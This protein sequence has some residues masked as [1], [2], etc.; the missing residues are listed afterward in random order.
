LASV[1]SALP[2]SITSA[3]R[4]GSAL[5]VRFYGCRF[6]SSLAAWRFAALWPFDRYSPIH[7]VEKVGLANIPLVG[8][9]DRASLSR[10]AYSS[11]RIM[12]SRP[13]VQHTSSIVIG[14]ADGRIREGHPGIEID[15]DHWPGA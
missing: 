14:V 3:T 6:V 5:P 15:I 12:T 7:K 4:F 1:T 10:I 2:V 9:R 13:S 11:Q 8:A